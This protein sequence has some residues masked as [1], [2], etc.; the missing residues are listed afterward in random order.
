MS[1]PDGWT[2]TQTEPE[3]VIQ[4]EPTASA[5]AAA[6]MSLPGSTI[7]EFF[8]G[9]DELDFHGVTRVVYYPS[10]RKAELW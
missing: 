2:Q 5:L 4:I 9:L 3:Y 1:F 10:Y 7:I 8:A 6:L